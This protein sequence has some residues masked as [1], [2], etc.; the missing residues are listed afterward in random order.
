ME[1]KLYAAS[2]GELMVCPACGVSELHSSK[3]GGFRCG[4]CERTLSGTMIE[5]LR[6]IAILP[7]VVGS[8][9]CECGHPEMKRLPGGIFHCPACGSEVLSV[10]AVPVAGSRG[11]S[12]EAFLCG[13]SDGLFGSLESFI[14]NEALAGWKDPADRLDYYRGHRAGRAVRF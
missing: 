8:H 6:E 12:S 9:P 1:P 11:S 7:D 10:Q 14:H 13:W 4:R 2:T 3:D 5:T